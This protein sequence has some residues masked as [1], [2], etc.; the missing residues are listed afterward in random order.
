MEN[1]SFLFGQSLS[2]DTGDLQKQV[3]IR[4]QLDLKHEIE[5]Y[6]EIDYLKIVRNKVIEINLYPKK[7]LGLFRAKY[8]KIFF[9]LNYL[10]LSMVNLSNYL[11]VV[12]IFW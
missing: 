7:S 4:Y 8:Q 9:Y 5:K 6:S 1:N 11:L 3:T 10:D 12:S 2:L